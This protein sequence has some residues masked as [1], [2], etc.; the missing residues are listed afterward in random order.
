[1]VQILEERNRREI[2]ERGESRERK[3]KKDTV[4]RQMR[5]EQNR[6]IRSN[7]QLTKISRKRN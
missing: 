5:T 2:Y 3:T 6:K 4:K 7:R 1:M